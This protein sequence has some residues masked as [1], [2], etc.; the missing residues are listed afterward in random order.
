MWV[1]VKENT[2]DWTEVD[3]VFGVFD[4]ENDAKNFA[5][6]REDADEDGYAYNVMSLSAVPQE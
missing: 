6:S 5:A 2:L 1:V 3:E 4:R